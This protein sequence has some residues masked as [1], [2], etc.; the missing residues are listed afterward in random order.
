MK[1]PAIDRRAHP[2]GAAFSTWSGHGGWALRRMDWPQPEGTSPRGS[3]I[4]A[5][6]RGD[7]VEKYLEA[8]GYGHGRGWNVTSFDWRGQGG[9]RGDIIGGHLESF[10]PLVEDLDALVEEW[11]S[12]APGPHVMVG[13][14]MGGHVLL[15]LLAERPPAIHAA[16]LVAPMIA[17]N[18]APVP[19]WIGRRVARALAGLG[20]RERPA[21]KHNERPAPPGLSRQSYL[22]SC[23]DRYS[24]E[25]WWKEQQPG[26]ALG[27][28]SWGWL[29][30]AY[31][32]MESVTPERM[33]EIRT[34]ILLVA[35]PRDR[36]V[37]PTAIRRAA[38]LLP[39]V[40]LAMFE[41]AAHELLRE[42]DPIR[43]E[44]MAGIDSFLDARAPA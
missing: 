10:D 14:S 13:H 3:L 44:V 27:P 32:S 22:T 5:N 41:R 8:L 40:E 37:S 17:I 26:F 25:M 24:D 35:T 19:A 20:W 30:A 43:L 11:I 33:R 2:Q 38:R 1:S 29:N 6:G 34:P 42:S 15:R 12:N 4:F 39:D 9:S 36:L 23:P 28:P 21:W 7:F 31:R 16:V 18:A